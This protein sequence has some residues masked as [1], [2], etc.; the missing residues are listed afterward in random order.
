M[1]DLEGSFKNICHF[2][3]ALSQIIIEEFCKIKNKHVEIFFHKFYF[4]CIFFSIIFYSII[5]WLL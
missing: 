4:I 3:K 5:V 1:Q 2:T